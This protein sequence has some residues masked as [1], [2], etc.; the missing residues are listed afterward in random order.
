MSKHS[1]CASHQQDPFCV[2]VPT[3]RCSHRERVLFALHLFSSIKQ[4]VSCCFQ[5]LRGDV[6]PWIKP[7]TASFVLGIFADLTRGKA[8]LLA[9]HALLRQP[10][11]I[12]HRQ[13]K[14][15]IYRKTDRL[16]FVLRARMVRT[17]KQ[18]LFLVQPETL[19][20]GPR[21]LFRVFWKHQS[22]APARK[23]RLSS[24]TIDMI[25]RNSSNTSTVG[26]RASPR[27]ITQ[28]EYS[29]KSKGLFRVL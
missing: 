19:L 24:E 10:L 2:C 1:G 6:L 4:R 12:L 3:R 28:A 5:T 23:P 17:W 25:P 14:R 11:I 29:Q 7:S 16:L 18:A 21:E 13:V 26:S 27:R 15:P 22:K 8:E 20:R 9:E